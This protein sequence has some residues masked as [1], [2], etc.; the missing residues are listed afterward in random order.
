LK[1]ILKQ[2]QIFLV[3]VPHRDTRIELQKYSSVL[4]NKITTEAYNFPCV[5]PLM[6]LSQALNSD[7]LKLYAKNLR[8]AAGNDK[9]IAAKAAFAGFPGCR[10]NLALYGPNLE[11]GA[12]QDTF[13]SK[14]KIKELFPKPVVGVCLMSEQ[15]ID[16]LPEPPELAFRAA[17]IANMYWKP[18]QEGGYKWKIDKLFWLPHRNKSY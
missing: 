2:T 3:L 11:I 7:E 9:I 15:K 16:S 1:T 6:E 18:L 10:N 4:F 5:A 8:K 13:G 14:T 17:A 12:A